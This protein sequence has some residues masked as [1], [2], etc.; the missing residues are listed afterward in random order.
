MTTDEDSSDIWLGRGGEIYVGI[1][2][3]SLALK[4]L[5][6]TMYSYTLK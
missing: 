4:F 1:I 2:L 6:G 3:H 5:G